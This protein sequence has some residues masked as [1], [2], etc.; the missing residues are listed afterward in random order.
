RSCATRQQRCRRR[1]QALL[2]S[3]RR[4]RGRQ[5]AASSK[6]SRPWI[7]IQVWRYEVRLRGLGTVQPAQAG[8]VTSDGGFN[9]WHAPARLARDGGR[10]PKL[11]GGGKERALGKEGGGDAGQGGG[12]GDHVH[13]QD[14]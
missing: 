3:R 14:L 5:P 7:E 8:F 11:V 4:G 6:A 13:H 2:R 9:P 12:G 10:I 1:R